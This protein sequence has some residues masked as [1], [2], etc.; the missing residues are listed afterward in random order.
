V[1]AGVAA[2]PSADAV[3]LVLGQPIKYRRSKIILT[4]KRLSFIKKSKNSCR[5]RNR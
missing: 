2:A 4:L 5:D 1:V 3:P